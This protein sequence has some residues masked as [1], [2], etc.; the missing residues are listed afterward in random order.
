MARAARARRV[1]PR[2]AQV[3]RCR[4]QRVA[5][6]AFTRMLGVVERR[7]ELGARWRSAIRHEP[8]P[9]L[10]AVVAGPAD[11]R[12]ALTEIIGVTLRARSVAADLDL[13]RG[14]EWMAGAARLRLHDLFVIAPVL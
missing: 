11:R 13:S 2:R 10:G 12:S 4:A 9:R 3:V 8:A 5:A 1:A 6:R 14:R 7:P